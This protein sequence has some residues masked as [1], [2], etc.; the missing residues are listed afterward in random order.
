MAG[1]VL[2]FIYYSWIITVIPSLLTSVAEYSI[3]LFVAEFKFGMLHLD[4][5]WN[6]ESVSLFVGMTTP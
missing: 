1:H 3:L 6:E 2:L 5:V 4:E